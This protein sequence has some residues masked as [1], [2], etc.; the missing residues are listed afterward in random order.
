M[1]L[2]RAVIPAL[3]AAAVL[4]TASCKKDDTMKNEEIA[5]TLF[6]SVSE[7]YIIN[8]NYYPD[9]TIYDCKTKNETVFCGLPGCKHEEDDKNC[10][11]YCEGEFSCVFIRNGY[12]YYFDT[13]DMTTKIYKA[14]ANGSNRKEVAD[15]EGRTSNFSM[16][17]G[18]LYFLSLV[19]DYEFDKDGNSN[20]VM[21]TYS[22]NSFNFDN[23]KVTAE[24]KCDKM[25]EAFIS[26]YYVTEEKIV[27]KITYYNDD[28]SFG[29]NEC[30]YDIKSKNSEV[31]S[32]NE[33]YQYFGMYK[34]DIYYVSQKTDEKA[35]AVFKYDVNTLKSEPIL[36]KEIYSYAIIKNYLI[37]KEEIDSSECIMINLDNGTEKPTVLNEKSVM[38]KV[39]AGDF[40]YGEYYDDKTVGNIVKMTFEDFES[41]KWDQ[42]LITPGIE[43]GVYEY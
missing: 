37:Y 15:V 6:G 19:T 40:V 35:T 22:I 4:F 10:Q 38:P 9:L 3:L 13:N 14:D 5:F 24:I 34:N 42:Y 43:N 11:A 30:V 36:E 41:G 29:C 39:S 7:D 31:F 20:G 12:T 17:N 26:S 23:E 2:K 16:C 28:N 18:R 21:Q 27:Y 25:K 32:D 1:R 33:D 8:Y